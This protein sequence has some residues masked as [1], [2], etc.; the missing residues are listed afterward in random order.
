MLAQE[1]KNL[2][3]DANRS[4]VDTGRFPVGWPDR[5]RSVLHQIVSLCNGATWPKELFA[6][7]H[8][9]ST[10]LCVRYRARKDSVANRIAE[11]EAILDSVQLETELILWTA[12]T[13]LPHGKMECLLGNDE[14]KL[15]TLC[16]GEYS[17]VQPVTDETSFKA[18]KTS[19]LECLGKIEENLRRNDDWNKWLCIA[20]HFAAF[21]VD[22]YQQQDIDLGESCE[23]NVA[24]R[25]L[26]SLFVRLSDWIENDRVLKLIQLWLNSTCKDRNASALPHLG[27]VRPRTGQFVS[28][29]TA[30]E[31]LIQSTVTASFG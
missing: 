6:S 27:K 24:S 23:S 12:V 5:Y 18:W 21:Y 14:M 31:L 17:P 2:I 28:V 19:Y 3:D 10:H 4:L 11:T 9:I 8:Y 15:I 22:L 16:F 13:K 25:E 1:L 30:T 26:S 20:L 29:R 7:L